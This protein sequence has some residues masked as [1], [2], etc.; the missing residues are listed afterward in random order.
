MDPGRL[1]GLSEP[2]LVTPPEEHDVSSS[3]QRKARQ[4]AERER[5]ERE[6]REQAAARRRR[7]VLLSVMS[8]L[9]AVM[10]VV[11]LVAVLGRGDDN[12]QQA[13]QPKAEN[14]ELLAEEKAGEAQATRAA[15]AIAANELLADDFS[16]EPG[17]AVRGRARP[18][19]DDRAVAC[20]GSVPP[21]ARAIRPTYPGGPTL[22]LE[23]GVDYRARITTSCGTIVI[24]LFEKEAPIAVNSF[25]FLARK[26]FY[27]GLEI[28]RDF[29]GITAVQAGS[30]TNEV[31]SN[32]GYRL[33]DELTAANRDGYPVGVVTTAGESRPY[34]GGSEF[35]IAYG[36]EYERSYRTNRVHTAF[37]QVLS[38]MEAISKVNKLKR[39]GMGGEAWEKRFFMESVIIE[40][41]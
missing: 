34:T 31:G 36:T 33:P 15:E 6:Q 11:G 25:V 21:N 2:H 12:F 19:R 40:Q 24:D 32:V 38:G 28:F 41:R 7:T 27:D 22:V 26:G 4:L 1:E 3:K 13:Q 30:G 39:I 37:G 14:T 10:V 5:W 9:V 35:L 18:P 17:T 8:A 20:G 23:K 29:G 16:V